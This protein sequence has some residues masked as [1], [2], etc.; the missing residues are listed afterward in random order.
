MELSV[1]QIDFWFN[2]NEIILKVYKFTCSL[3]SFVQ[4]FEF[5]R[6]KAAFLTILFWLIVLF[7]IL[8]IGF[9]TLECQVVNYSEWSGLKFEN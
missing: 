5:A 9:A 8:F 7:C 3:W 4:L 6:F 2:D 1:M